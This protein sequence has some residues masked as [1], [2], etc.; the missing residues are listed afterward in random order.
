VDSQGRSTVD[1]YEVM[2]TART[3]RRFR[4][5]P[6]PDGVLHRCLEAA[7]WAP[8]GGNSQPWRFV[9]L[10]SP[11]GRAAMREGAIG[12]L[13]VIEELYGFERPDAADVSADARNRRAVYEL[14]D[15]A[16]DVPAGVLFAFRQLPKTPPEL[17]G[18]GVFAAMENFLLACRAEGLGAAVT[19]WGNVAEAA[20]RSATGMPEGWSIAALVVVGW[21]RGH[22]GPVQRKPVEAVA[23]LDR[24]DRPFRGAGS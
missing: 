22:H 16:A 12:S 1:V 24:W 11:E 5:E 18:S 8:S 4:D 13:T 17:Q 9:V 2:R 3:I 15:T 7:T 23:Y 19:G 21:P 14:H 10:R 20:M 6:V